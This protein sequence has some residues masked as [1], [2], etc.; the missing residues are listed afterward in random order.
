M[1]SGPCAYEFR[2]AFSCFHYSTSEIKG[3]NCIEQF[4]RLQDC[5]KKYPKL[6]SDDKKSDKN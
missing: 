2:Q 6:Y 1:A 5:M 3:T 4:D